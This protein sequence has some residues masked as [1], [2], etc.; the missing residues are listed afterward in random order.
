M[1]NV[2]KLIICCSN[3]KTKIT[4]VREGCPICG[5]FDFICEYYMNDEK[6]ELPVSMTLLEGGE[7]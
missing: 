1:E 5:G 2:T 6:I 4:R 3:C 7:R